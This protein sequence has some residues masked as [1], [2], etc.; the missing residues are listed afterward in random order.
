MDS[1]F[2]KVES[3]SKTPRLSVCR[4][5]TTSINQISKKRLSRAKNSLREMSLW[6]GKNVNNS[7]KKKMED[8]SKI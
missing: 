2:K 8:M 7:D 1:F 6:E 5:D 4:E 3:K